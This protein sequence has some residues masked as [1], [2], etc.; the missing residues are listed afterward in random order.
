M[1]TAEIPQIAE[2]SKAEKI[3][4]IEELW[5]EIALDDEGI[6]V[7]LSHQKELDT[8]LQNYRNN[9]GQLLTLEEL[10]KNINQLK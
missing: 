8:R 5:D 2:L 9:P 10:Q 4:L 7:P 3:L 6:T 1:K